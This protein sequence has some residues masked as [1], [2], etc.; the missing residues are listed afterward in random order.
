MVERYRGVRNM[1]EHDVKLHADGRD[2][3][4]LSFLMPREIVER[5]NLKKGQTVRIDDG[6]NDG[7]VL[8]FFNTDN[9]HIYDR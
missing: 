7:I 5:Y 9:E 6:D 2:G 4:Y 1:T 8:M 3:V